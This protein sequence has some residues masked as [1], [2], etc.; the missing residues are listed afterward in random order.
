MEL[1]VVLL[2]IIWHRCANEAATQ[3]PVLA[4]YMMNYLAAFFGRVISSAVQKFFLVNFLVSQKEQAAM[5][6][7]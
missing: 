1:V 4:C 6:R 5:L 2:P 3:S 7:H